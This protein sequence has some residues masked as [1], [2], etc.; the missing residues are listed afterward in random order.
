MTCR[1]EDWKKGKI[2]CLHIFFYTLIIIVSVFNRKKKTLT[3]EKNFYTKKFSKELLPDKYYCSI[4]T[5]SLF[6]VFLFSS[7]SKKNYLKKFKVN[8]LFTFLF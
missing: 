4:I 5:F 6:S 2:T 7:F 3:E 1:E 8:N